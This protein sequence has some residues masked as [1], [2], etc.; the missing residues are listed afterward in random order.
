MKNDG[1]FSK[2]VKEFGSHEE[3]D[4]GS[5]GAA[6]KDESDGKPDDADKKAVMGATIMQA[7]ER[8]TG[9]VSS[10]IYKHYAAAG[11]GVIIIPILLASLVLVQ[12]ATVMSSYW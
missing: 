4:E 1:P 7:E 11:H 5:G 8:N 6:K 10:S 2:F 12:G 3:A 9:A